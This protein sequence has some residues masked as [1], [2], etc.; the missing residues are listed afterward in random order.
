MILAWVTMMS[1]IGSGE[2][3]RLRSSLLTAACLVL[4]LACGGRDDG[5]SGEA[6]EGTD[7]ADESTE[8]GDDG[9]S[10]DDG[11]D[12]GD[13]GDDGGS[14]DD[15]G[16]DGATSEDTSDTG[17]VEGEP[18]GEGWGGDLIPGDVDLG[19]ASNPEILG[20][21]HG[22]ADERAV[23][24][25][26]NAERAAHGL[27]PL[28]WS[29]QVANVGR[30]HAADMNQL[31]Y[32][33]HGSST[34]PYNG[35]MENWLPFPRLDFVYPGDFD[36]AGENIAWGYSVSEVVPAWMDSPGHRAAILDEYGWTA[37]HG[38]VGIDDTM[39]VFNPATCA[40]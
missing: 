29:D 13:T 12:G 9:G 2:I 23:F 5:E 21:A 4:A 20:I 24:D 11:D 6:W 33:D 26:I 14:G 19:L 1:G 27:Q 3:T 16:D 32:F 15:G 40:Q 38:G 34:R 25:D 36:R 35:N 7:G 30:S 31:D 28:I 17:P 8:T 37:T 22:Q 39:Y 10:G 18:C